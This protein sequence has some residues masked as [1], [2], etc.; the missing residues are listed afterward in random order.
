MRM[1]NWFIKEK[2]LKSGGERKNIYDQDF[3]KA[4][5]VSLLYAESCLEKWGA[6]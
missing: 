1:V 5:E 6:T 2:F 4:T 3:S